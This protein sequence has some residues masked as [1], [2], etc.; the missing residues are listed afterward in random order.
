MP[1]NKQPGHQQALSLAIWPGMS[2]SSS[3]EEEV[4][5]SPGSPRTHPEK[6]KCGHSACKGSPRLDS[7]P[8]H[9]KSVAADDGGNGDLRSRNKSGSVSSISFKLDKD[10][11]APIRGKPKAHRKER[12]RS[13]SPP[14]QRYVVFPNININHLSCQQV[15]Q[16]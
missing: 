1:F 10:V 14:P 15:F 2:G 6:G 8:E 11:S 13:S 9:I 7:I 12:I 5:P 16:P 4:Q 3:P